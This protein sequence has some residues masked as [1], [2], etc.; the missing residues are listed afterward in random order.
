MNWLPIIALAAIAFLIAAF[1]LRL[2]RRNW[3]FFGSALLF[4]L[5]GYALHGNPGLPQA[6]KAPDVRASQSGEA[7]VAARQE[8]FDTAQP[9]PGYLMVSDAFARKGRFDQAAQLLRKG[10]RENPNHGEG[11]LA[12]ANALVEHA[13][14][15]VTP[16]AAFAFAKAEESMPGNPGPAYF[17]G[18]SLL[19]SGK[20]DE[21][22]GVWQGLLDSSPDD[23]PWRDNLVM[24]IE[25][26][27]QLISLI[28]AQPIQPVR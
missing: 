18:F 14:G 13:E 25:R 15:Q 12:L 24:R 26:L 9:R 19:R 21:A 16:P 6:P 2:P 5:A 17:L 23:A 20:P 10:L 27:D 11:W 3:T 7:M 28:E 8:L 22:R 4:G 1:V